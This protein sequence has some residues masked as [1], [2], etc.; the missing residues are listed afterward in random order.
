MT[1]LVF[2]GL[3]VVALGVEALLNLVVT[4]ILAG[5]YVTVPVII[6]AIILGISFKL[7]DWLG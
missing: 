1:G 5:L 6:L 4:V 7:G 2:L 3:L